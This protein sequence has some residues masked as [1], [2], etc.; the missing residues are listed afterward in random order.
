MADRYACLSDLNNYFARIGPNALLGGLTEPEKNQLRANIGIMSY[1]GEGGQSSP[2]ELTYAAL[3]DLII[4]ETLVVGARYVITDFRSIY[5]SNTVNG[6]NQSVTWGLSVNPSP[7]YSMLV[8]A[9]T[10]TTL[11]KRVYIL[12]QNWEV[13]YDATKITLPDGVTTRGKITYLK[14]ANGNSAFYDFKNI[15]FRRTQAELAQTNLTINSSYIDLFTFSDISTGTP[16]DN[17]SISTTKYN[18]LEQDCWNNVFIGDTYNNILQE[19]CYS[20]TFLRGC[21]DSVIKWNSVNNLFN[22][23]VCYMEGSIY[24]HTIPVGDTTLSTTITKNIHKV[25]D[26]TIVSFLD[27]ITYSHQI[28]IL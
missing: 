12:G 27:P 8:I 28:I 22:E 16:V 23:P 2:V 6:S 20:N 15:R 19:N 21:H 9:N 25:N 17:S 26:A 18:Q 7:V 24:N 3:H 11:D 5:S 13:E 14:D 4:H 10:N 1:T